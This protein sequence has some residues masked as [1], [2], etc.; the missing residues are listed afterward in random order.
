MGG[1]LSN[2]KV[3]IFSSV[4]FSDLFSFPVPDSIKIW[5]F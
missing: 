5:F 2:K 1:N 3:A 4:K